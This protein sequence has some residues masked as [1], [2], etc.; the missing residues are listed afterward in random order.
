M[1]N[2]T[3]E[4]SLYRRVRHMHESHDAPLQGGQIFGGLLNWK[5]QASFVFLI[6]WHK[7]KI[8]LPSIK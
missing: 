1:V 5:N 4:N 8:S 6:S 2:Y 3:A 7:E